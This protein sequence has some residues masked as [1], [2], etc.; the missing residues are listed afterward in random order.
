MI[1]TVTPDEIR[2][3]AHTIAS[4][5]DGGEEIDT[6]HLPLSESRTVW[7][8]L[9][10]VAIAGAGYRRTSDWQ[11]DGARVYAVVNPDWT[12]DINADGVLINEHRDWHGVMCVDPQARRIVV[13]T[14]LTSDTSSTMREYRQLVLTAPLPN[15]LRPVDLVRAIWW[16]NAWVTLDA[17]ADG[18]TVEIDAY[19]G[20]QVGKLTDAAEIAY[21][22]LY[23]WTLHRL[24]DWTSYA[25][26][27]A[28]DWLVDGAPVTG[29]ETDDDLKILA[30]TLIDEALDHSNVVVNRADMLYTLGRM[31]DTARDA[32]S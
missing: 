15:G 23:S 12:I 9:A 3:N 25:L 7:G 19:R 21:D 1:I 32:R 20:G 13:T 24:S 22:R 11:R 18:H 26:W 4:V 6:V 16:D 29:A 28:S 27:D 14:R 5:T 2:D 17:I 10:D 30:D 31:R 8:E